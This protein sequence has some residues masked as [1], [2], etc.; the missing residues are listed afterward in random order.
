[1][2]LVRCVASGSFCWVISS[3]CC[4][5]T[6]LVVGSSPW[7]STDRWMGLVIYLLSRTRSTTDRIFPLGLRTK[8][9]GEHHAE[10]LSTFSMVP[11]LMSSSMISFAAVLSVSARSVSAE[12]VRIARIMASVA[13]CVPPVCVP[14]LNGLEVGARRSYDGFYLP[15]YWGTL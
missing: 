10:I 7:D 13:P 8:K 4:R 9:H 3:A 11:R 1:M 6:R 14:P 2:L 12:L 15:C 5:Y